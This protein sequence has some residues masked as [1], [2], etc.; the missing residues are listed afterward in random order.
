[1][2]PETTNMP[3]NMIELLRELRDATKKRDGAKDVPPVYFAACRRIGELLPAI[4]ERA[5][6]L[7]AAVLDPLHGEDPD[8]EIEV[9]AF[10][11]WRSIGRT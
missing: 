8:L 6:E 9:R 7:L 4:E 10:T 11:L 1:M 2:A 5:A 3:L